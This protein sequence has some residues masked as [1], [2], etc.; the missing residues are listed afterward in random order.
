MITLRGKHL[1]LRGLE[2]KDIDLLE[3]TENDE[4]LWHLSSTVTPFSRYQLEQYI[5]NAN[6]DLY[7]SKQLR[8]VI[9]RDD[10]EALGFIDLYN[11]DPLN[12]RA[13]IGIIIVNQR[14][15]GKGYAKEV[16]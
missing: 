8:L 7:E 9:S 12:M 4:S 15:R 3:L 16:W 1:H 6:S 14:D 13:G 2:P 5:L 11:F 10:G